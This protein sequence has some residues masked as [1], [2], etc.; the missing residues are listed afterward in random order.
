[1]KNHLRFSL[2]L[3]LATV[4]FTSC[5]KKE[6]YHLLLENTRIVDVE[7]GTIS[8]R[9]LVGVTG[10]SIRTV[11]PMSERNSV[12]ADTVINANGNYLMPGLWD[13]HVHFRG[14]DT[15]IEENKEFLKMFLDHGVTTVRDAG[16]DMT[17]S[18]LQWRN[19]I[20]NKT[21]AGPDIFTSGPKLDGEKPAWPGSLQVTSTASLNSALDSLEKVG[22]D[23][24]KIYDGSLSDTMYYEIIKGAEKRGL[25]V[26]GHMP[27]D[28]DL[29]KAISAGLDGIEHLYYLLASTS[30]AGDSIRALQQGYRSLPL[31]LDT[32]DAQKTSKVFQQLIKGEFYVTPTLHITDVLTDLKYEDHRDDNFLSQIGDGIIK[33]YTRREMAAKGRDETAQA[34]TEKRR[35]IF[36]EMVQP[37]HE[38]GAIILAGSD[39]GAFNS[40][41]YPGISLQE[42]LIA[43]TEAGL[44]PADALITSVIHGPKFFGLEKSYGKISKNK[45]AHMILLAEDP[46]KNIA[47]IRGIQLVIKGDQIYTP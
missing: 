4:I 3:L 45:M 34:Y 22:A 13:M 21:L 32:Y 2:P 20:M 42:E 37:L 44:S 43:L 24:V 15:L 18:L 41:V 31:L 38:A 29:N 1:M 11:L 5:D 6:H 26:T 46:L 35:T 33:T 40:Y 9:M 19:E 30:S 14:G 39:C 27:M 16:G 12:E 10:D 28:A 17:P 8:D 25:K 23:Y 7:S 47:A 36:K